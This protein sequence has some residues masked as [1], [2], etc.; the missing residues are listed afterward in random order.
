MLTETEQKAFASALWMT[1]VF[2]PIKIIYWSFYRQLGSAI[3]F[4][5][6]I[7]NGR[8]IGYKCFWTVV[9]K[10][11]YSYP[12]IT[13]QLMGW[14][15]VKY[16]SVLATWYHEWIAEKATF[17]RS[18]K[19][20]IGAFKWLFKEWKWDECRNSYSSEDKPSAVIIPWRHR[21]LRMIAHAAVSNLSVL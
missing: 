15:G 7:C 1:H 12:K 21:I 2:T 17:I 4:T 18:V 16:V 11:G 14:Q 3:C 20:I 5:L 6:S 9:A 19:R 10:R 13:Y 8:L